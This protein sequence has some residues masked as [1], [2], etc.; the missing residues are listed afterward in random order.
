MS[1]LFP[2]LWGCEN[3]DS[4]KLEA[5]QSQIAIEKQNC[6]LSPV[7]LYF[8]TDMWVIFLKRLSLE[9]PQVLIEQP[10]SPGD[11]LVSLGRCP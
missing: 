5:Y 1:F 8:N 9:N 7:S 4:E 6:D 11:E 2:P 3:R 10:E